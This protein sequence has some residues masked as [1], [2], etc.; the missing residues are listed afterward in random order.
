MPP[1]DVVTTY[2]D[3]VIRVMRCARAVAYVDEMSDTRR[4]I[5]SFVDT[6]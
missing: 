2:E 4:D 1:R 5:D 6:L 3:D